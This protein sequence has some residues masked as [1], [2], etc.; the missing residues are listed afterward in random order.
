MVEM[1]IMNSKQLLQKALLLGALEIFPGQ[2]WHWFDPDGY[3][4][5]RILN[6]EIK[7][8]LEDNNIEYCLGIDPIKNIILRYMI[9]FTNDADMI[10]FKLRWL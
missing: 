1:L 6:V 5:K 10:A 8:W 9:A 2:H 7:E 4:E 3:G